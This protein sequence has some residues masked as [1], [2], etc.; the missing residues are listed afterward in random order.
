MLTLMRCDRVVGFRQGKV[1]EEGDPYGLF[2]REDSH[3][4]AM[5]KELD[6]LL[7]H[8]LLNEGLRS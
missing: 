7:Y 2:R 6:H 4:R 8:H 3:Y 5:V 1:F